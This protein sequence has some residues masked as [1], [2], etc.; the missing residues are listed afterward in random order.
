MNWAVVG[1]RSRSQDISE[2]GFNFEA[3]FE[4]KKV[5]KFQSQ[6]VNRHKS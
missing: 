1:A 3:L 5:M 6:A 2:N 4:T